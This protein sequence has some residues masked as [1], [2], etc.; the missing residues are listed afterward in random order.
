MTVGVMY[1]EDHCW[2]NML[3]E[4]QNSLREHSEIIFSGTIVE[5]IVGNIQKDRNQEKYSL[6]DRRTIVE[7][8]H[9]R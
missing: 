4:K 9:W 5:L 1:M 2:K 6:Q 7:E 3:I 8:R